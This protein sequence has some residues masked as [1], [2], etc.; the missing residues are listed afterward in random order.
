MTTI[1]EF[2]TLTDL[3]RRLM[4]NA[5]KIWRGDFGPAAE[6]KSEEEKS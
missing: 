5:L 4:V 6:A 2:P 3:E 1:S